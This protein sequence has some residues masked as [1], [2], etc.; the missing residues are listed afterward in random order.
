MSI[1]SKRHPE[2]ELN[3]SRT[4]RAR[5]IRVNHGRDGSKGPEV[6]EV[7]IRISILS[8]IEHIEH[9]AFELHPDP[10]SRP[11]LFGPAQVQLPESRT[12]Q[13]ISRK[14]SPSPTEGR[15]KR[16]RIEP[17]NSTLRGGIQGDTGNN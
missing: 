16:S 3:L 5:W 12:A 13:S 2:R 7:R 15:A 10:F 6:R 17:R 1:S 8:A 9:F 14:R 11:E 4:T